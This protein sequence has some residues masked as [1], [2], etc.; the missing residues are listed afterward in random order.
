[1]DEI[2]VTNR[3]DEVRLT[4]VL[5]LP[6]GARGSRNPISSPVRRHSSAPE[7]PQ[8]G[9]GVGPAASLSLMFAGVASREA[10]T[11]VTVSE[12]VRL[13]ML[14]ASFAPIPVWASDV[15]A[16]ALRLRRS[17]PSALRGVPVGP[18]PPKRGG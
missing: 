8:D 18:T 6:R 3:G 15:A 7:C 17:L 9:Y 2:R 14:P 13:T 11:I 12:F 10:P 1:N 16:A 5:K 4:N